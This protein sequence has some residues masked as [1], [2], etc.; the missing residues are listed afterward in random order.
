MTSTLAH[1][2]KA[3]YPYPVYEA[4]F[5]DG[6]VQRMSFFSLRGKPW[7][8]ERGRKLCVSARRMFRNEPAEVVAGYV[9]WDERNGPWHRVPDPLGEVV[10]MP[11]RRQAKAVLRRPHPV[12]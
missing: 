5:S 6:S 7:D 10:A 4:H 8:F 1:L 9:E 2:R 12:S 3:V 11:K